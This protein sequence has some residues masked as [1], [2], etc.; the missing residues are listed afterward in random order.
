MSAEAGDAPLTV[1]VSDVAKATVQAVLDGK[2]SIYVHPL[3]KYDSLAFK[4]IPQPIFRKLP[5]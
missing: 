3:F 4:F 5:Y 1:N 2:Q